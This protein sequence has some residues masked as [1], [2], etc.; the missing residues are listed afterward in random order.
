[1]TKSTDKIASTEERERE[2]TGSLDK[3]APLVW[4]INMIKL[5]SCRNKNV[6]K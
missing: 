4:L 5:L 3:K 2:K 1:M 6:Q